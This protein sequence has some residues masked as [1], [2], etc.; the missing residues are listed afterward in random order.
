MRAVAD[1]TWGTWK[2][3]WLCGPG[4]EGATVGVVGMGRIG[5]AV[6]RFDPLTP[7]HSSSL[8][9]LLFAILL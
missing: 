2:P 7:P 1:G 5:M 3:L 4:L 6:A 9:G 8:P